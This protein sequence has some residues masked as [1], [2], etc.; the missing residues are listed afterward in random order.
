M[1]R[2]HLF[3]LAALLVSFGISYFSSHIDP[4]HL[5]V[6][7]G[8]GINIVLAT[9]LN[10]VNG[11]TGQF[12]LGHAGF[13]AVGAYASAAVTTFGGARW[14]AMLGGVNTFS[15]TALFVVALLIGGLA[16]AVAGL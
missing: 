15:T 13:M 2:P 4:Y 7:I 1:P 8:I 3:L 12:S 5:D 10:L 9:S 11:Y 16:A 6:L 14:F